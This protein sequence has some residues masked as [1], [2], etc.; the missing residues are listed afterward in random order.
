VHWAHACTTERPICSAHLL[1][2]FDEADK[3]VNISKPA[4]SAAATEAQ[5]PQQQNGNQQQ[6]QGSIIQQQ[7]QQVEMFEGRQVSRLV[8]RTVFFDEATLMATGQ[9]AL[10][11]GKAL[12]ALE[13][14]IQQH[15]L[16]PC[17]QVGAASISSRER[18]LL[19]CGPRLSFGGQCHCGRGGHVYM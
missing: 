5:Q 9:P 4:P 1:Q 17:R 12:A 19:R 10:R 16:K 13:A 3:S 2:A 11:S 6:Q 14:H 7:Q 15:Q 8:I 18:S